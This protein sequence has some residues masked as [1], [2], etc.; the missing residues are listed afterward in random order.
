MLRIVLRHLVSSAKRK[1]LEVDA[2]GGR[3]FTNIKNNS[4]PRMLP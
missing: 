1:T 2:D 4:G 3:S